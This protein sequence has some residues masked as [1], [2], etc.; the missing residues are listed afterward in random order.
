MDSLGEAAVPTVGARGWRRARGQAGLQEALL[1]RRA[2]EGSGDTGG[3]SKACFLPKRM[4]LKVVTNISLKGQPLQ[5]RKQ[6]CS[7][8][9]GGFGQLLRSCLL[10]RAHQSDRRGRCGGRARAA[11]ECGTYSI[12]A[13]RPRLRGCPDRSRRGGKVLHPLVVKLNMDHLS[14]SI[15][16]DFGCQQEKSDLHSIKFIFDPAVSG[17]CGK[18]CFNIV[19]NVRCWSGPGSFSSSI[20]RS[21]NKLTW[22]PASHTVCRAAS[23]T[24]PVR[25]FLLL[26]EDI[27]D[28]IVSL[29]SLPSGCA[30]CLQEMLTQLICEELP[31]SHWNPLSFWAAVDKFLNSICF[32]D[33]CGPCRHYHPYIYKLHT[34]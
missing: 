32:M 26:M 24:A 5:C 8:N 13:R 9:G 28:T 31:P 29:C 34:S 18:R 10:R 4:F 30:Q 20:P 33:N 19:L 22:K 21:L 14:V 15:V 16:Q 1:G 3:P 23:N 2:H 17:L 25:C 12:P 11:A 27:R 7:V 6:K